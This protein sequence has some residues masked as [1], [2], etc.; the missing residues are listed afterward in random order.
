MRAR[1]NR[2]RPV[3]SHMRTQQLLTA[4]CLPRCVLPDADAR[5]LSDADRGGHGRS[6]HHEDAPQADIR[7]GRE[8]FGVEGVLAEGQ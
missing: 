6:P 7:E 1:A 5:R 3:P 8:G 2:P 4:Y